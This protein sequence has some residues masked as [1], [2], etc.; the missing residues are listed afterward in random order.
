MEY[1]ISELSKMAGISTRTLRYYDAIGLLKPSRVNSA[2]YRYYG[3]REVDLLWQILFY[4]ERGLDLKQIQ[5]IVV[6]EDCDVLLTL[7][8]HLAELEKEK[9]HLVHL[10]ST[11]NQTIQEMKGE[12][13]KM[14]NQEKFQALKRE[15]VEKNEK[16]YGKEA[17]K[18][19]GD[20]PVNETNQRM[21]RLTEAEYEE[22]TR[23]EEE[24]LEMLAHAV[25]EKERP[26]GELGKQIAELHRKWLVYS[27][28]SYSVDAHRGVVRMYTED[29]RFKAYY[30]RHVPGCA[31]FLRDA[32]LAWCKAE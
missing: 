6:R 30:D 7:E 27:W 4:R 11:V 14:G 31:E 22:M 5:A 25:R 13:K 21:L 20:E 17:R 29:E 10:I 12:T 8:E 1:G 3:Q 32:V 24:I 28:T 19:Y 15:L 2:G 23:L 18:K 16:N 26:E 9:E